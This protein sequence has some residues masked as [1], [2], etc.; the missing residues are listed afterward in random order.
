MTCSRWEVL[1]IEKKHVSWTDLSNLESHSLYKSLMKKCIFMCVP[2]GICVLSDKSS[3]WNYNNH[4]PEDKY[5]VGS[6]HP[7]DYRGRAFPVILQ[8]GKRR[9]LPLSRFSQRLRPAPSSSTWDVWAG[10][11]GLSRSA[12][13]SAVEERTFTGRL[14]EKTH[15]ADEIDI[16]LRNCSRQRRNSV[17]RQ[18]TV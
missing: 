6:K 9:S 4:G 10:V 17:S 3:N 16:A 11:D 2:C 7:P 13:L 8:S 18:R 15:N 12:S 1:W 5:H 14:P